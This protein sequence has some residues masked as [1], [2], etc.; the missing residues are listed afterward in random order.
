MKLDV[1]APTVVAKPLAVVVTSPF[2]KHIIRAIDPQ[3]QV[4]VFSFELVLHFL[5][6]PSRSY[7]Q[8]TLEQDDEEIVSIRNLLLH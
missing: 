6:W 8:V 1:T 7:W 2:S 3:S 4:V 5:H